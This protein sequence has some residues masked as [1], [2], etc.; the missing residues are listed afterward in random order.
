MPYDQKVVVAFDY[1][2]FASKCEELGLRP[3]SQ[4]V[5]FV[6]T[7]NYHNTVA[8]LSGRKFKRDQVVYCGQHLNGRHKAR[9]LAMLEAHIVN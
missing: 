5:L 7:D 3:H 8:V 1:K 6:C 9:V 4:S 2:E